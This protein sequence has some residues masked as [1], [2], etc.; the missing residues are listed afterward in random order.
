M[1]KDMYQEI[2]TWM[3]QNARYI[4]LCLWQY[5]FEDGD[6]KVVLAALMNYQNED[7]GFG[8]ALEAD[9]W[10][11][12][13]TPITTQYA[14]NIL[15]RIDFWDMRHPVYQGIWKYL[16]AEK[17][18]LGYGWR[19]TVPSNDEHPHAPWW[20]YS[21]MQ[22]EKEYFGVTAEFAAFILRFGDKESNL[23]K[24]AVS[25]TEKLIS[26]LM[27]DRNYGDMGLEGYITLIDTIK[28]LGLATYDNHLLTKLLAKKI[29]MAIEHDTDKWQ[30]YGVRPS[31]Y[32]QSPDSIFYKD[33]A[34]II[35]KE[36]Q[37]LLETK[38]KNDVWGITWS[39]FD[40][41]EKYPKEFAISENWWKGYGVIEK[42]L[43]LR[44]FNMI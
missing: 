6:K 1:E 21:E 42:M 12:N 19:F 41:T 22:N 32:I 31:N 38:P 39:W 25:F 2:R 35:S 43:F 3:Y 16:N 29:K 34:E 26:M 14:L 37:Y 4:D 9:N 33:N 15:R 13:S 27:L 17:D 11:P 44:N 18:L 36:I 7:G 5:F 28:D 23:Y 30:Y 10:N 8:H 24:K 20:N 40:N